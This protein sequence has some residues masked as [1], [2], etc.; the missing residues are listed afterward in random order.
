MHSTN[1]TSRSCCRQQTSPQQNPQQ[2]ATCRR[3]KG[4]TRFTHSLLGLGAS[5]QIMTAPHLRQPA[6]SQVLLLLPLL[7]AM[8]R[9][10]ALPR[11]LR[12]QLLRQQARLSPALLLLL[13]LLPLW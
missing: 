11:L 10:L 5:G 7:A 2:Q 12:W 3:S 6:S 9:P 1:G 13:V 4:I 8:L